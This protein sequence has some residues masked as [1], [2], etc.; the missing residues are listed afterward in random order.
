VNVHFGKLDKENGSQRKNFAKKIPGN[1]L[2]GCKIFNV[3]HPASEFGTEICQ[4]N[5]FML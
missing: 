5:V 4:F 1:L 2:L 3:Y